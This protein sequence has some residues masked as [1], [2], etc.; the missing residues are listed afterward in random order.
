MLLEFA[1]GHPRYGAEPEVSRDMHKGWVIAISLPAIAGILWLAIRGGTSGQ[2]PAPSVRAPVSAE[3]EASKPVPA[4]SADVVDAPRKTT[5]L[6]PDAAS[7]AFQGEPMPMQK[8]RELLEKD[9]PSA[10]AAARKD[11]ERDPD[12]P[13]AAER[14]WVVVKSLAVEGRFEDAQREAAIMVPKYRGTRWADD[15]ER[16]VLGHPR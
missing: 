10:R 6:A 14:Y 8:L 12:G 16:H 3:M 9:P 1:H 7:S 11:L 2:T 5:L 4:P 15:V 13:D